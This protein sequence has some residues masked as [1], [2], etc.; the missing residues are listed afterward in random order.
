MHDKFN[1]ILKEI[2]DQPASD[3]SA[4]LEDKLQIP[5][6]K[7]EELAA[8]IKKHH[9]QQ[10]EKQDVTR[11]VIEKPD[12][13]TPAT[14]S[15]Y[16][17]DKLSV[18]EFSYFI[19]WLL[20]ELGYTIESEIQVADYGLDMI[21]TRGDE[22]TAVLARKYPRN[23]EVSETIMMLSE[24]AKQDYACKKAV[25]IATTVFSSQAIADAQKCGV[26]LWDQ[27]TIDTQIKA[28][29][30][31]V[32]SEQYTRFPEFSGSLLE[33]LLKLDESEHF[34]VEPRASGKYDLH[35][36]E[37][38]FPLLTFQAQKDTVTQCVYRIKDNRPMGEN[39]GTVLIGTDNDGNRVGPEDAEAYEL[40]TRYLEDFLN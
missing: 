29:R 31:K 14:T 12:K 35:L 7:A 26:E 13:T 19:K 11:T 24:Q 23:Y 10:A 16:S 30:E 39:E 17:T 8:R 34:I 27:T 6:D 33:W 21:V 15:I 40:I 9:I 18:R 37:V 32:E 20:T 3:V 1:G 38:K 25:I 5:P 22:K 2:R 36:P 4:F 28:V